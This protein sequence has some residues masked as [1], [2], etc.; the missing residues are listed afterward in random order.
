MRVLVATRLGSELGDSGTVGVVPR[1]RCATAQ[2][3]RWKWFIKVS[4][5]LGDQCPTA[6]SFNKCTCVVLARATCKKG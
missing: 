3:E 4:E 1:N 5:C 2:T 6:K